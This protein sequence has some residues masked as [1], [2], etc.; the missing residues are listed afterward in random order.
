MLNTFLREKNPNDTNK[1]NTKSTHTM[2]FKM[3]FSINTL[4]DYN[5]H[6]TS[7]QRQNNT[8]SKMYIQKFLL[9]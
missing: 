6:L 5:I 8:T 2:N 9:N 7:T 1:K 4:R 3:K